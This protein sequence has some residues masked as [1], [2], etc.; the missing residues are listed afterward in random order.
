MHVARNHTKYHDVSSE[1]IAGAPK[2][3][4]AVAR[5]VELSP[6]NRRALDRLMPMLGSS[7]TTV[8]T[9]SVAAGSGTILSVLD[10]RL[11][12]KKVRRR[13]E[14]EFYDFVHSAGRP[15]WCAEIEPLLPGYYGAVELDGEVHVALEDF[16]WGMERPSVIDFK[17]GTHRRRRKAWMD[18]T[19]IK[20]KSARLYDDAGRLEVHD[21][22]R[23]WF[24]LP[25]EAAEAIF[26]T[27]FRKVPAS[28]RGETARIAK[29]LRH[30][31]AAQNDIAFRDSSIMI[32]WEMPA[33]A[34]GEVQT[35]VKYA[36]FGRILRRGWWRRSAEVHAAR[37]LRGFDRL[38]EW[39][40]R[41]DD[42][43]CRAD[44]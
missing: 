34:A 18:A 8:R 23:R 9:K 40:A 2:G 24:D 38:F 21:L 3:E 42:S 12:L 17:V 29:R 14:L 27:I 19:L 35:R 30:I 31:I 33:K 1:S 13:R 15:E 10:G 37:T 5:G 32:V 6:H 36:D 43:P 20:L 11:I 16:T 4:G 26:L 44:P 7:P 22:R 25:P 28:V 39:L 41:S